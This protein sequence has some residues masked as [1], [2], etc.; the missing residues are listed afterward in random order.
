MNKLFAL[1]QGRHTF[2]AGAFSVVG[3][4]M[5]WYHKLDSTYVTFVTVMMGFILGHSAKEDYFKER[6][7][8]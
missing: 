5:A 6:D 3:T 2:F 1:C 7:G 4:A 8:K